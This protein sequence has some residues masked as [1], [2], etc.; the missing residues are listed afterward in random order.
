MSRYNPTKK[1]HGLIPVRQY[2]VTNCGGG[3]IF[4]DFIGVEYMRPEY[5]DPYYRQNK[6]D[7]DHRKAAEEMLENFLRQRRKTF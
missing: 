2:R 3:I 6:N 4:R 7:A 5:A 1:R